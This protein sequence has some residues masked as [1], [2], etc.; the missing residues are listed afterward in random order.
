MVSNE[1]TSELMAEGA[2]FVQALDRTG[3]A[4]DAAFWFY[5]ADISAWRL[6]LAEMKSRAKGPRALYAAI[7]KALNAQKKNLPHLTLADIVVARPDAP[8]VRLLGDAL[9]TGPGISGIRF[10]KN[11][12]NG[13]MIEDAY[14]YRLTRHPRQGPSR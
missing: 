11:V 14:I 10:S 1:L 13:T 2:A 5:F 12:V 6:V 4:P 7:Q 8:I 9:S 3:A